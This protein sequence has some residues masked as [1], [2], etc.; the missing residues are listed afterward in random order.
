[1][2]DERFKVLMV[3]DDMVLRNIAGQYLSKL[4]DAECVLNGNSALAYTKNTVPDAV[5]IDIMLPDIDGFTLLETWRAD[6]R[7]NDTAL[8][9]FSN[10]SEQSD[11]KKALDMG[12]DA[13]YVKADVDIA[14]L[15]DIIEK[16]IKK[17]RKKGWF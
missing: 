5:L 15:P 10:L 13:Y 1:M 4:M 14:T 3:E 6:E 2:A 16:H 17:R 11:Q 9:M 7:F 8:I 12:A